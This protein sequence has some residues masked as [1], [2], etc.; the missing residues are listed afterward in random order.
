MKKTN[1]KNVKDAKNANSSE[2]NCGGKCRS[3]NKESD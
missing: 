1:A 3:Q 2:K